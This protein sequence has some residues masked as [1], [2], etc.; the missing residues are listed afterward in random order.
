MKS[1][2]QS[3]RITTFLAYGISSLGMGFA[4]LVN[5]NVLYQSSLAYLIHDHAGLV[6]TR[7]TFTL[8]TLTS[9]SLDSGSDVLTA[10]GFNNSPS[11]MTI[12]VGAGAMRAGFSGSRSA[13]ASIGKLYPTPRLHLRTR[14]H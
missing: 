9:V 10:P 12:A 7:V 3:R 2:Q 8:T 13:Q 4:L 11:C 14:T 5:P 1:T 6:R